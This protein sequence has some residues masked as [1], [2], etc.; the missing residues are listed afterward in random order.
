[1][2]SSSSSSSSSSPNIAQVQ[3]RRGV[4]FPPEPPRQA[5]V[6]NDEE[7]KKHADVRVQP[8][9]EPEYSS[10]SDN[11]EI[12]QNK[13]IDDSKDNR[14]FSPNYSP[15]SS[16]K[17]DD[18]EI[19]ASNVLSDK[20]EEEMI[21]RVMA[22][23]PSPLEGVPPPPAG[24]A[25]ES[26]EQLPALEKPKKRLDRV[27]NEVEAYIKIGLSFLRDRPDTKWY[28]VDET[29]K[30]KPCN[31]CLNSTSKYMVEYRDEDMTMCSAT[32]VLFGILARFQDSEIDDPVSR[33]E[34]Q[35]VC[36]LIMKKQGS[37]DGRFKQ[38]RP[39]KPTIEL[40]KTMLK[41][42]K[43]YLKRVEEL[44][45]NPAKSEEEIRDR[46]LATEALQKLLMKHYQQFNEDGE[47]IGNDKYTEELGI[48]NTLR[49]E[50]L[51]SNRSIA[52]TQK[53]NK[54]RLAK[55]VKDAES[56]LQTIQMK[57]KETIAPT[58]NEMADKIKTLRDIERQLEDAQDEITLKKNELAM[59]Y[60]D[61]RLS[62]ASEYSKLADILEVI[63]DAAIADNQITLNASQAASQMRENER[64]MLKALE[65]AE[66]L[67][68]EEKTTFKILKE[69]CKEMHAEALPGQGKF[70]QEN[71]DLIQRILQ[72]F[73]NLTHFSHIRELSIELVNTNELKHGSSR[74][75]AE[76]EM[77]KQDE[78]LKQAAQ[79]HRDDMKVLENCKN[80]Y[81]KLQEDTAAEF[82]A[83]AALKIEMEELRQK[84]EEIKKE[85]D[86]ARNEL[87]D[88]RQ[89]AALA[90]KI[91]NPQADRRNSGA[92]ENHQD[93]GWQR[94]EHGRGRG[95]RYAHGRHANNDN[96]AQGANG[97]RKRNVAA[98]NSH[99]SL[100]DENGMMYCQY[101]FTNR[102]GGC[103][104][105]ERCKYADTHG[106]ED[107]HPNH[108]SRVAKKRQR[109]QQDDHPEKDDKNERD[110]RNKDDDAEA[111][112]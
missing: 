75:V 18:C 31:N 30:K 60:K 39:N 48:F 26:K 50:N 38:S 22:A 99:F 82:K 70:L 9:G 73:K 40:A 11:N 57:Y 77:G 41:Q 90:Q 103:S 88:F 87:K 76:A 65:E 85:R 52:K 6:K 98:D 49:I 19:I 72:E 110:D 111:L 10:E 104:K 44:K 93:A 106:M 71:S 89:F 21:A 61:G 25:P 56:I 13:P 36:D 102:N 27:G 58:M 16:E 7:E 29:L 79:I 78:K 86:D 109:P 14:G 53:D 80:S 94:V 68:D 67:S 55:A 46:Q 69:T 2:M 96:D 59:T 63:H 84:N 12:D 66:I 4:V 100:R 45:E 112:K 28:R 17:D 81:K 91:G 24:A 83:F 47:T 34:L 33:A 64:K 1:M 54:E 32:C 74:V 51:K 42:S 3:P 43:N 105:G 95:G 108:E 37:R 23:N 15:C 62:F 5:E 97:D 20:E 35:K 8:P 92:H 101:Q 107:P